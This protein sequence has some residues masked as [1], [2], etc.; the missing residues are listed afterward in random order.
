M[1]T[2]PSIAGVEQTHS[3]LYSGKLGHWGKGRCCEGM[4]R[5]AHQRDALIAGGSAKKRQASH[6]F[7]SPFLLFTDKLDCAAIIGCGVEH[8]W[9]Q[10]CIFAAPLIEREASKVE[11]QA[12]SSVCFSRFARASHPWQFA[13]SSLKQARWFLRAAPLRNLARHC[14]VLKHLLQPQHRRLPSRTCRRF[15]AATASTSSSTDSS[16]LR[17]WRASSS[18]CPACWSLSPTSTPSTRSWRPCP[19]PM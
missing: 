12:P 18:V 15:P 4:R 1:C 2:A 16:C 8:I 19:L 6:F 5:N 11:F 9:P 7:S 13:F 14:Q 17:S 3:F 10:Q